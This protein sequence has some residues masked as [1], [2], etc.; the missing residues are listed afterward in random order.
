MKNIDELCERNLKLVPY[1]INKL[2]LHDYYDEYVD[3]GW[4]GLVIACQRY[5][6]SL[7]YSESTY[8]TSYIRWYI[9][10][11]L[12]LENK[13]KKDCEGKFDVSLD[14]DVEDESFMAFVQSPFDI[15]DEFNKSFIIESIKEC[16]EHDMQN[17][18]KKTN[19]NHSEVIRDI[20]GFGREPMR[21]KDI[22]EK[23]NVS[24]ETLRHIR[25]KFKRNLRKRLKLILD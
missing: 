15:D 9:I 1:V 2:G 11:E 19:V 8:L 5:D 3:I 18:N 22:C 6:E 20:Y 21:I 4:I 14:Y 24:R 13:Y 7:G 17:R 23:Y 10:N 16:L 25:S 12:R